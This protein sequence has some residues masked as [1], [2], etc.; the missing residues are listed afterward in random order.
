MDESMKEILAA[1]KTHGDKLE[2]QSTSIDEK[3]KRLDAIGELET[4]LG[5]IE[6][7]EKQAKSKMVDLPGVNEGA[8][9]FSFLKS[10]QGIA[11]GVWE[12]A[13]FEKEVFDQTKKRALNTGDGT[14][15]GYVVPNQYIA[16]VI[17]LIK[18]ESVV[19]GMGA[20]VL[21]GLVGSPVEIPK[22]TGGATA[23]WVGENA[24]IT[25]S[26]QSFGQLTMTPKQVAAMVKMSNRFIALSD[27]SGEAMVRRD[28]G[29]TIALAIDLAALRGSGTSTQPLGIANT[30]GILTSAMGTNGG[31]FDWT[32]ASQ[33]EGKLEDANT[34]RGRLGYV[35][36]PKVRRILKN[37]RIPQYSGQLDGEYVFNPVMSEAQLDSQLGSPMRATTQLPTNLTKGSATAICSEVIFGNWQE[38]LIGQWGGLE[39]MASGETSDAFAK[40]QTWIRVIQE[41]DV[42]LRHPESFCLLNDAKIDTA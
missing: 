32:S 7:A 39:F 17:E 36:H 31:Y 12:N 13:G 14:L 42:A 5:V 2:E 35:T 15:G 20:N 29:T 16:E 19:M 22:Q 18:A 27:P 40:N 23:Y 9:E 28:L 1:I 11:T 26:S 3:L 33:M 41:V 10:F 24:P 25:E 4:R 6:T 38:L 30:P 37:I 21:S 34:L 8:E